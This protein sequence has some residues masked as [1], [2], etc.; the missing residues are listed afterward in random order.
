MAAG[1]VLFLEEEAPLS[2]GQRTRDVHLRDRLGYVEAASYSQFVL[3][4]V[5]LL[6]LAGIYAIR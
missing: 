1:V 5:L 6:Y 4:G 2:F 3:E